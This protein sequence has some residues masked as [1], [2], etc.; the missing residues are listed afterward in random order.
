M[1]AQT[2]RQRRLARHK[3]RR[4]RQDK[5]AQT[6]P[7]IAGNVAGLA[8]KVFAIAFALIF[9]ITFGFLAAIALM[10]I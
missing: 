6:K 10:G 8:A 1:S 3:A 9:G 7:S 5:T 2:I 4:A